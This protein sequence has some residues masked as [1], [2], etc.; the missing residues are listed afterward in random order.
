MTAESRRVAVVLGELDP[1]SVSG[2]SRSLLKAIPELERRGWEFRFWTEVPSATEEWL[3]GH[4]HAVAGATR[5]L[6]FS[7]RQL[8]TPPGPRRRLAGA[9]PYLRE[10]DRFLAGAR[11]D[12]LLGNTVGTLPELLLGKARGHQTILHALE[13]LPAAPKYAFARR[14]LLKA[15]DAIMVPSHGTAA[16]F[17]GN[18]APIVVH[19]GIDPPPPPAR[20]AAAVRRATEQ[21]PVV[22]GALGVIS[23]RKGTD[24]LVAAAER[25]RDRGLAIDW[26][27]VGR[28]IEGAERPDALRILQRAK[29]AGFQHREYAPAFS[30]LPDWDILVLPSRVDPFPNVVLEA[31]ALGVPVIGTRTGGV[32]EQLAEGTGVLV[33]PDDPQELA[34]AV[35]EL[36]ADGARRAAIGRAAE[37]RAERCFS[38]AAQARQTEAVFEGVLARARARPKRSLR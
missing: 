14:M 3:Q 31:M 29:E 9:V 13:I 23:R 5:L 28:C 26:R 16:Q 21:T 1:S 12:L 27:I 37:D 34:E 15:S 2:A 8:R 22:V 25:L 10:F 24:V 30:V 17:G 18:P 35:A 6:K 19:T 7:V 11:P 32:P 38:V 20:T 36:A 4:G 33:A